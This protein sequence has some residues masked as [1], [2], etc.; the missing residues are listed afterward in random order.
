MEQ[1]PMVSLIDACFQ[2]D[3]TALKQLSG[4]VDHLRFAK[5]MNYDQILAV[6]MEKDPDLTPAMWE[7]LMSSLDDLESEGGL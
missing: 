1:K 2:G 5:R 7:S 3:R 6:F 4:L